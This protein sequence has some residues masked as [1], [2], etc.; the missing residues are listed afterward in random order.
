MGDSL[1]VDLDGLRAVAA[2][3]GEIGERATQVVA[4]LKAAIARAGAAWG[5]D[6]PGK[7]FEEFYLPSSERAVEALDQMVTALEEMGTRLAGTAGAFEAADIDSGNHVGRSDPFSWKPAAA[8]TGAAALSPA[9]APVGGPVE[10]SGQ[11]YPEQHELQQ[12]SPVVAEPTADGDG[13][14]NPEQNRPPDFGDLQRPQQPEGLGP[15]AAGA[16]RTEQVPVPSP[17]IPNQ[18][19]TAGKSAE[20]QAAARPG[21]ATSVS[22]APGRAGPAGATPWSGG[23]PKHVGGPPRQAVSAQRSPNREGDLPPRPMSARPT[24][25]RKQVPAAAARLGQRPAS[26][27]AAGKPGKDRKGTRAVSVPARVTEPEVLRIAREMAARHGLSLVGFETAGIGERAIRELAAAIDQVLTTH[28]LLD[29]RT[30]E[31]TD[32]LDGP[33]AGIR[34]DRRGG[35]TGPVTEVARLVLDRGRIA[36]PAPP[37]S[38]EAANPAPGPAVGSV[39]AVVIR[40]LGGA[41]VT[42]GGYAAR[43]KV[44]RTLIRHFMEEVD[45]HVSRGSLGRVVADYRR[46]RDTLPGAEKRTSTGKLDPAALLVEA[47][48]DVV[49][50]SAL[51]SSASGPLHRLLVETAAGAR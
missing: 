49:V 10:R 2:G 24:P 8:D 29:L 30:V 17:G 33:A 19:A 26:R 18:Q 27:P 47:F 15:E 20:S 39:H 41:L 14:I 43:R 48:A 44:Q 32:S 21:S 36:D 4:E 5:P 40:E 25:P 38:D 34:W 22:S 51:S 46:W 23:L 1:S 37:P 31:I 3:Q 9:F 6:K 16:E 7:A 13:V 12:S 50:T 35:D 45:P 28:H 11:A 42:M